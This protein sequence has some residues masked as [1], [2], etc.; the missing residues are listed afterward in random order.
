MAMGPDLYR[1][2]YACH[3]FRD[4]YESFARFAVRRTAEYPSHHRIVL[5]REL[6]TF[7]RLRYSQPS[8][9][10]TRGDAT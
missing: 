4:V 5:P 7:G 6:C 8:L 9:R 10:P 1:D 3:K 2:F